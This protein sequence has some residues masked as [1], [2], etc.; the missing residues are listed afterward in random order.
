MFSTN[1]GQTNVLNILESFGVD[2]KKYS[3]YLKWFCYDYVE[4]FDI[5]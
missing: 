1:V 4:V 5:Y 2:F 3:I